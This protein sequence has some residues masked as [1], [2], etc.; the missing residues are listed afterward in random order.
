MPGS[1]KLYSLHLLK[2]SGA[3]ALLVTHDSEE[4]MFMGDRIAV[5]KNGVTEQIG[6]PEEIYCKPANAFVTEFFSEVNRVN[7]FVKNGKVN[8]TIGMIDSGNIAGGT[9]VEILIR[10]E[11][12]R[13]TRLTNQSVKFGVQA[14]EARMLGYSSLIHLCADGMNGEKIHL[15]SRMPG[16]FLPEQNERLRID[17]DPNQTFIFPKV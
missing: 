12:L 2:Q 13:L 7:G 17:I 16:R 9:E 3:A 15:H 4:A 11:A 1:E 14:L 8:T 10:P 6:R 5:M